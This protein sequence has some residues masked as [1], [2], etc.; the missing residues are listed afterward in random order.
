MKSSPGENSPIVKDLLSFAKAVMQ[1]SSTSTGEDRAGKVKKIDIE[2]AREERVDQEEEEEEEN[3]SGPRYTQHRTQVC[4]IA[5]ILQRERLWSP[6]FFAER[7][8]HST[9]EPLFTYTLYIYMY[10]ERVGGGK[11]A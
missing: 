8:S 7:V 6:Y 9:L 5:P 11:R 4:L 1:L 10:I 3:E 2:S